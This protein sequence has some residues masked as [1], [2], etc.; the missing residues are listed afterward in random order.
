MSKLTTILAGLGKL[1][2]ETNVSRPLRLNLIII[3]LQIIL[4]VIFFSQLPPQVP[5]YYSRPWGEAQL[6]PTHHLFILPLISI[7]FLLINSLVSLPFIEKAIFISVS[8]AWAGLIASSLG[9]ITLINIIM[10]VL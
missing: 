4:I 5:L 8:L 9:L 7:L 3:S 2:L 6:A 10:V 1:W